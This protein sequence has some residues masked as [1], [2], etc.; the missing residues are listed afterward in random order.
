MLNMYG[1][2]NDNVSSFC[3]M[4]RH[5]KLLVISF[6]QDSILNLDPTTA[7]PEWEYS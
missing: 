1:F 7:Y 5:Y 4:K 6:R 2:L 3:E